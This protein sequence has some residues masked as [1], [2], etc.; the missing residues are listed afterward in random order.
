MKKSLNKDKLTLDDFGGPLTEPL[1]DSTLYR[2]RD[3]LKYCEEHNV[4][5]ENLS[6]E[7]LKQFEL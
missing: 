6:E 7:E 3:L 2:F 4:L 1:G 5:P